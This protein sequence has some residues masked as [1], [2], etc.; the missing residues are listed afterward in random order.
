MLPIWYSPIYTD[1]LDP[2]ARFPRERYRLVS[3]ALG[4][5]QE[6][7]AIEF[8]EP[9]AMDPEN[10]HLV[11]CHDYVERFLNGTLDDSVVRRIGLRPW[12]REIVERTL[13]LTNG[14]IEATRWAC[15]N[16][17][18]AANLGGGTHHAYYDFGSGYCIF[19][20]LAVSAKLA[21]RDLGIGPVAILDLDVHQGDG[22]AALFETDSTVT[23]VSFHCEKNFP[24]RKMRSD[25]DVALEEGV[26]DDAYLGKLEHFLESEM[27]SRDFDLL[28]F[29]AGVDGLKTDRLGHLALTREG[30]K[31]RNE[32]VFAF[33]ANKGVPLVVTMGGGYGEPIETSVAAHADLFSG[34][35]RI[36]SPA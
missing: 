32:I 24:F 1:G 17:G 35:A 33:A 4:P 7:G 34:A 13:I 28:F 29:Q 16:G 30:M 12:T 5:L 27:R 21:Q 8:H 25:F 6:E 3:E 36:H 10:L 15:S 18:V 14:T 31:Q 2:E 11:H 26:G 19:N 23:A 20:D 9:D 22:T